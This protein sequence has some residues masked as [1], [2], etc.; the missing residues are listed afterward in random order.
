MTAVTVNAVI[1][2]P[3][4]VRVKLTDRQAQLRAPQIKAVGRGLYEVH[5]PIQFKVGELIDLDCADLPKALRDHLTP[6]PV[7]KAA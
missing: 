2:L 3:P 1:T 7:T 6:V 5:A 4:G